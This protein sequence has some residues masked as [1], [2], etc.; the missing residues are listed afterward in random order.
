MLV[1]AKLHLRRVAER[2]NAVRSEDQVTRPVN[3]EPVFHPIGPQNLHGLP[4]KVLCTILTC[5]TSFWN[6]FQ[7]NLVF[8]VDSM[9]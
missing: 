8:P 2:T 9:I 6:S 7:S 3:Y 1:S 4:W 5:I